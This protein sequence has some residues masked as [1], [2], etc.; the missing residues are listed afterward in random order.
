MDSKGS[1]GTQSNVQPFFE[2]LKG[3]WGIL[4]SFLEDSRPFLMD[5][6]TILILRD[7]G[8]FWG[9]EEEGIFRAFFKTPMDV[10]WEVGWKKGGR[11]AEEVEEGRRRSIIFGR[12]ARD[13]DVSRWKYNR[14][15]SSP[16]RDPRDHTVT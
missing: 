2:I 9:G 15:I 13:A 11:R 3:F 1:L 14:A 16:S 4:Q 10:P 12:E 5:S 6:N 7:S 8:R